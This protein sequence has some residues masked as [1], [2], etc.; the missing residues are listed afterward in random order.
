M[1]LKG[2]L[3]RIAIPIVCAALAALSLGGCEEDLRDRIVVIR[4]PSAE[5]SADESE[6]TYVNYEEDGTAERRLASK[7]ELEK[8]QLSYASEYFSSYLAEDEQQVCRQL[9]YGILNFEEKIDYDTVHACI[10]EVR[11]K[12]LE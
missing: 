8:V 9:Y 11:K 6:K 5:R 7:E 3:K 1:T 10:N 4:H 2:K 12:S